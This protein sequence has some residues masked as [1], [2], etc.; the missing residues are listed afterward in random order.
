M[1]RAFGRG[2]GG[3][4]GSRDGHVLVGTPGGGHG[5]TPLVLWS[6]DRQAPGR[7]SGVNCVWMATRSD[8]NSGPPA[9]RGHALWQAV[10]AGILLSAC[11]VHLKMLST[12]TTMY[13]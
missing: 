9:G 1:H 6:A 11:I 4:S 10:C 12:C 3:S 7:Q 8:S 5:D 13:Q 2:A